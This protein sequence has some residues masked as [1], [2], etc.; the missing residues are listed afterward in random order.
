M[1]TQNDGRIVAFVFLFLKHGLFK[2]RADVGLNP[3][4][5]HMHTSFSGRDV[6]TSLA[7]QPAYKCAMPA[8]GGGYHGE[9]LPWAVENLKCFEST[10]Q[11]GNLAVKS[12]FH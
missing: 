6:K 11:A 3:D 8:R 1:P 7:V 5:S 2:R 10:G 12:C 4:I 9:G